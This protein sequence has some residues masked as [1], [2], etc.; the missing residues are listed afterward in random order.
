MKNRTVTRRYAQALYEEGVQNNRLDKVDADMALI[1]ETLDASREL[2]LFFQSPVI[3]RKKKEAVV[4]E[5]FGK[6]LQPATLNFLKLLIEKKREDLFPEMVQAYS[7][8]RDEQKGIVEANARVAKPLSGS[9]EKAL[10]TSLEKLTGK[11][12][13]LVVEE[14]PSL[15]GGL[16]VRVGDTVYDGSVQHKLASLRERMKE[17]TY[18]G[19]GASA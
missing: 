2:V 12:I 8:L 18:A 19:N 6:R 5:L 1:Q 13:R 7:E 17:G 9:E 16:I 4:Q 10:R 3:S 14:D 11:D 15:I